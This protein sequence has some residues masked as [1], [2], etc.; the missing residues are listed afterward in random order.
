MWRKTR[1]DPMKGQP[2]GYRTREDGTFTLYSVG[3]NGQDDD[4]GH[5]ST[6]RSRFDL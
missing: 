2:F 5:P 6:P 3:R 4:D 1:I